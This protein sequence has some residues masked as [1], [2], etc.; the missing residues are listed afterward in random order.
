MDL[1]TNFFWSEKLPATTIDQHILLLSN[2]TFDLLKS[3]Q[4]LLKW[5]GS[6]Y[7]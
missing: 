2:Q 1:I 5:I 6:R 7:Y 3:H 4:D